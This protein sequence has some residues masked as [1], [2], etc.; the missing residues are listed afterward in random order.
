MFLLTDYLAI[1]L[2]TIKVKN[3]DFIVFLWTHVL[4]AIIPEL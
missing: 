3:E 1:S 2:N 4:N